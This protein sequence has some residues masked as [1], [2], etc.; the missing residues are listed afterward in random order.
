MPLDLGWERVGQ[1]AF[2]VS[3]FCGFY[4]NK[5]GWVLLPGFSEDDFYGLDDGLGL[6]SEKCIFI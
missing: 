2:R 3:A 5:K 4:T 1:A 6:A